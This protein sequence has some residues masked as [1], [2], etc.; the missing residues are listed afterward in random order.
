VS[1]GDV[2]IEAVVRAAALQGAIPHEDGGTIFVWSPNAAEQI[3][4]ALA[5]AGWKLVRA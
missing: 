1:A 5:E 3:E 2:V 4:G